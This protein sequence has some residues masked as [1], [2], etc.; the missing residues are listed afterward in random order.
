[1][2]YTREYQLAHGVDR[3]GAYQT[4]LRIM[5]GSLVVGLVANYFVKPVEEKHWDAT[6]LRTPSKAAD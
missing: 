4:V 5:A 1:M 2:N 3:A 6:Q